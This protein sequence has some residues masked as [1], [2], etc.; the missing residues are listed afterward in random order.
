MDT[1]TLLNIPLDDRGHVFFA[2]LL[3]HLPALPDPERLEPR[4]LGLVA[5]ELENG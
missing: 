4:L 3:H 5:L 1:P 2:A